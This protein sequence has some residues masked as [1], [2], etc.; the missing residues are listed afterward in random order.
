MDSL[1]VYAISPT[2]GPLDRKIIDAFND[3]QKSRI[4]QGP[5][6]QVIPI[7][8]RDW[9]VSA[10]SEILNKRDTI[11]V[12][13][14]GSGK[15]LSY[16]LALIANPGKVLQAIFPLLSLMTDQVCCAKHSVNDADIVNRSILQSDWGLR[17]AESLI[18]HCAMIRTFSGISRI[19]AM[20]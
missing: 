19:A 15:S 7:A 12:T 2:D 17:P 1:K 5:G 13:A 18:R 4:E 10:A 16:L 20:N 9:Q 11:V 8:P 14:T 6:A 3:R